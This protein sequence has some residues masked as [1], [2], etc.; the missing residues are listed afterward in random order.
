MANLWMFVLGLAITI[1]TSAL[2]V[3]Y[4]RPSLAQLLTDLCGSQERAAFWT[5]FSTITIASVPLIF[6]LADV[7]TTG[8]S[9][10]LQIADQLKWGLIGMVLS[11]LVLGWV[12]R[13]F[14]TKQLPRAEGKS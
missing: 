14:I 10:L 4:L 7:P 2:V 6:A 11:V 13:G 8:A 12:L 1:L 9:P 5:A 3:K